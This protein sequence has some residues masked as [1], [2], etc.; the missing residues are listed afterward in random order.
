M[1]KKKKLIKKKKKQRKQ[2]SQVSGDFVVVC[3][4]SKKKAEKG[5]GQRWVLTKS[6]EM[7]SVIKLLLSY[8]GFIDSP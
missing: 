5:E 8:K 7:E 1:M 4:R 6:N 3:S 2:K